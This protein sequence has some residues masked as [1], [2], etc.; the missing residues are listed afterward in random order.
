MV[1]A[2]L[3]FIWTWQELL[4]PFI[5]PSERSQYLLSLT[6]FAFRAPAKTEWSLLMA[7]STLATLPLVVLLFCTERYFQANMTRTRIKG[8]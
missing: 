7:A 2:L 8:S 3:S 5:Y 6:L 1:A 4:G